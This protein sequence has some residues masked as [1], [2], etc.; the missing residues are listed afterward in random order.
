MSG[1]AGV[2][3]TWAAPGRVNVIG[4]H[5]DY[6]DGYVLPIALPQRTVVTAVSA[7][8]VSTVRSAQKTG[9]VT[10]D[11]RTVEPDEVSGW[12]AYVAGVLWALRAA[13]HGVGNVNL[14]ID[15]DVPHGAGLSSSAALTC[16]VAA[17]CS[18]L[19]DLGLDRFALAALAQR[20]EN[21]F[22]GMP[23]GIMDQMAAM[24]STAGHALFLDTRSL[25]I[26]HVPFHFAAAGLALL[27][28]DTRA[29]HRLVEGEYAARR[30]DCEAAAKALGVPALRDASESRLGELPEHVRRRA[31]HVITEN[32][33]V[34]DAVAI[35]QDGQDPRRLGPLLTASHTS[36]RDDFEVSVAET[37]L[38][39]EALLEGGAYGARI[40]GGGFGGCVI[41][42]VDTDNVGP[43]TD[44]VTSAFYRA[45]FTEPHAFT[46]LPSAGAER[47]PNSDRH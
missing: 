10:F 45:G 29:P 33:R 27:V 23:C 21:D 4:E 9:E 3:V 40:T 8:T 38:A 12:G 26:T 2:G 16:A 44:S 47:L 6:N 11:A 34:L 17:A 13:R 42:L 41:G 28:V 31:R 24:H 43:A 19:F 25:E 18:D 14:S 35:L 7:A 15:S 20:A 30:A 5:T 36:L 1:S 46:A 32:T 22:V 39:V 37:D